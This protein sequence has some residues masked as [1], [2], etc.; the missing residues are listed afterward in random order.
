MLYQ[1]YIYN[2]LSYFFLDGSQHHHVCLNSGGQVFDGLG[3]MITRIAS[4]LEN[5]WELSQIN[6]VYNFF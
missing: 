2:R 1:G 4:Q 3:E 6:E 5:P